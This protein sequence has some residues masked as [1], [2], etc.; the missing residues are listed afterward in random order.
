MVVR[1]EVKA[2]E[3]AQVD[4]GYA[5]QLLDPASDKPRPAWAFVMTL[6][7]G[8]HQYVEFVFD[9][10]STTW[11]LCHRHACEYFGDVPK[12]VV[13]D[14]LKA[15]IVRAAWDDPEVQRAY[16][17]CAE[18]YDFLSA[19]CRSHTPEHKGKVEQGG[20][21]YVK[22]NFL[23]GRQPTNIVVAN[24]AVLRW[25]E[26]VAGERV[27]GTTK[28]QPLLRFHKVE[29]AA[30]QPLPDQPYEPRTWKRVKLHRD[31]YLVFDQAFYSTPHQLVGQP[32]WPCARRRTVEI[33]DAAYQRVAI[34]D[35]ATAPGQRL[36]HLA[37]LP[38][39]KVPGLL[40]SR[41]SCQ[42]QA[43]AI[44][45]ATLRLVEALLARRPADRLRSAGRLLRL[46]ERFTAERLEAACARAEAYGDGDYL[47][48]KHILE[49]DLDQ[50]P[51]A[52]AWPAAPAMRTFA[53]AAQQFAPTPAGGA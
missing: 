44:G 18:H 42:A 51:L 30:L 17:E 32:L 15:A 24:Q 8:R 45:P 50:Q 6:S 5:G 52:V 41:P 21:H 26:Q 13:V 49:A 46:A 9:Q 12:R 22:R 4:F 39:A 37:H 23:A 27:H 10:K 38:P 28:Q 36:T 25:C 14:N 34:H 7:W 20:V 29:Q 40:L 19:P 2:G 47:T 35:R 3:E 1:I 11:L 33:Y 48:V 31:C 53:R 16:R 43:A